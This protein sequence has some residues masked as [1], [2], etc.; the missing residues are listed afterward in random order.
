MLSGIFHAL[1]RNVQVFAYALNHL[2]LSLSFPFEVYNSLL[3]SVVRFEES[4]AVLN[5]DRKLPTRQLA[6]S[7]PTTITRSVVRMVHILLACPD[8]AELLRQCDRSAEAYQ[9][10]VSVC[11]VSRFHVVRNETEQRTICTSVRFVHWQLNISKN[12]AWHIFIF[13]EVVNMTCSEYLVSG[14]CNFSEFKPHGNVGKTSFQK[15]AIST[16]GRASGFGS[17][18]G[19]QI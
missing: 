5:R 6:P 9:S 11:L 18:R 15:F 17:F 8:L 3:R 1:H 2:H 4:V 14:R 16:E 19:R 12:L 7:V 10:L 13:L